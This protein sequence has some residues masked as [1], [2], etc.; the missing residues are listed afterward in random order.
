M[1]KQKL[2]IVC[3]DFDGVIHGYSKGWQ[4]GSIYDPPVPG[5]GAA[6]LRLMAK[7]RVAI[8]SS[9]SNSLRQ[10]QAMR[11][12]LAAIINRAVLDDKRSELTD[13][14]WQ[15][16]VGKPAD[17]HP[18]T[19]GDLQDQINEL[20]GCIRWPWFKPPA[21]LTIDDRAVTFN[22]DWSA[23]TPDAVRAFRPWTARSAH[24]G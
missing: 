14:A 4:D 12:Y 9:R 18:L 20:C 6:I 8:H 23:F 19:T 3:I 10:R 7:Y 2:P 11:R 15:T 5:C 22:G 16:Q 24:V 21:L 17:W 1:A 13:A